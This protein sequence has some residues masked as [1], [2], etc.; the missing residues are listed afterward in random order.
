[1]FPNTWS[2]NAQSTDLIFLTNQHLS[3]MYSFILNT[4]TFA[5]TGLILIIKSQKL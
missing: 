3:M 2:E 1:M 5:A 4:S